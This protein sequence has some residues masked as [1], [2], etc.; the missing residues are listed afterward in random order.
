MT[1]HDHLT[2]KQTEPGRW[3]REI[4]EVEQ[5]YTSLARTYAG[6]GRTLFAITGHISFSVAAGRLE[7]AIEA[8]RN[9][10]LRLRYDHP[11][12]ASWVEYDRGSQK[13]KKVYETFEKAGNS[14]AAQT[15][16]LQETFRVVETEGL[17]GEQWCNDDPPVPKLPTLFVIKRD[18]S[19]TTGGEMVAAADLVL[20]AHHDIIDGIGTLHLFDNLFRHASQVY[21]NWP[22]LPSPAFGGEWVNL[23]P[24]LRVAASIPDSLTVEQKERFHRIIA[25]NAA[26]RDGARLATVPF[27]PGEKIPKRHQRVAL[28]LSP[29]QSHRLLVT[30]KT[31]GFSVTHVYHAA[32][33]LTVRDAQKRLAQDRQVRYISYSLI[34]ERAHCTQPFSTAQHAVSVYHS[35][36][37]QSMAIDLSVPAAAS[38]PPTQVHARAEFM[39]VAEQVKAYYLEIRNDTEHIAMVPSYWTLSTLPYPPETPSVPQPNLAPSASISSMGVI[40]QIIRAHRG[41]F[42]LTNPWVT[43]EELGTGLGLFL[44]TFKGQICLSAAYNDAWHDMDEVMGLVTRCNALVCQSLGV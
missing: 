35:V 39:K 33:A 22:G 13:C 17:T 37:G 44:G 28:T 16:W 7:D 43:G 11:T 32:I 20:R 36:S 8:L 19:I 24:P 15:A 2:W 12:L 25:H 10:W 42:E 38:P 21:E 30:C 34:N 5:C 18:Q 9:A 41:P 27:R 23:S 31:L 26:L 3:E 1:L 6:S 14:S 4:D 29:E 40:D